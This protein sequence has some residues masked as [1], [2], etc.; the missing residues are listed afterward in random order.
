MAGVNNASVPPVFEIVN[1]V[2]LLRYVSVPISIS[3]LRGMQVQ[4][5]EQQNA[6]LSARSRLVTTCSRN[7][8][9]VSTPRQN[10][11]WC[12]RCLRS[13]I[14][15]WLRP[16]FAQ[17]S[18]T[19]LVKTETSVS[20]KCR[21]LGVK[22]FASVH[23]LAAAFD[24]IFTSYTNEQRRK[25]CSECWPTYPKDVRMNI[26]KRIYSSFNKQRVLYS[27]CAIYWYT[28]ICHCSTSMHRIIH[29]QVQGCFSLLCQGKQGARQPEQTIPDTTSKT[30]IRLPPELKVVVYLKCLLV[31]ESAFCAATDIL[32]GKTLLH[33]ARVGGALLCVCKARSKQH[34]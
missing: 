22:V 17:G 9:F 11:L 13:Y 7:S 15:L 2:S 34:F 23:C 10:A 6:I 1:Y 31:F 19:R 29:A 26:A 20:R 12:W 16:S 14:A 24:A 4:C 8:D 32:L 18:G 28:T 25:T 30:T 3:E 33:I 5:M 21:N 27:V